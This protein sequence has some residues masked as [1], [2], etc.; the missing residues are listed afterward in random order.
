VVVGTVRRAVVAGGRVGGLLRPPVARELAVPEVAA[1]RDEAVA[2]VPA[3]RRVVV[4]AV[5]GVAPGRFTADAPVFEPAVVL[6]AASG[7]VA[8]SGGA[9]VDSAEG[10]AGAASGWTAGVFSLSDMARNEEGGRGKARSS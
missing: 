8:G 3:T 2:V 5:A 9:G 4:V 10:V 1:A 6:V 7:E